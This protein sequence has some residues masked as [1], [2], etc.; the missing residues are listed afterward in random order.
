MITQNTAINIAKWVASAGEDEKLTLETE[1]GRGFSSDKE[2]WAE[3]KELIERHDAAV[4][5]V[6]KVKKVHTE[7]W[8]AIAERNE[9]S[10]PVLLAELTRSAEEVSREALGLLVSAKLAETSGGGG[11]L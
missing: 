11:G 6:K 8:N 5:K 2:A 1:R 4:K 7:L 9:D 3:L 10:I